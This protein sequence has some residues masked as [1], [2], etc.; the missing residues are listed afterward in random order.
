MGGNAFDKLNLG[1]N[2]FP[3]MPPDT[4]QTRKRDIH[5]KLCTLFG[6]VGT[7]IER[8]NKS[9]YGDIDFVVCEPRL[10]NVT[11]DLVKAT[12]NAQ[13]MV[14][15]LTTDRLGTSNFALP[16]T[17]DVQGYY[18]VDVNICIDRD[19]WNRV[20]FFHSYGDF[21]MILGLMSKAYGLS[22]G[23]KGLKVC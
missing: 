8:P 19:E 17:T 9:D 20:M 13:H 12:I 22:V 5:E 10:E 15:S 6:L 16:S 7:P 18:Q 1:D 2:A 14:E 23:T 4:Y 11:L 3:R 21:G